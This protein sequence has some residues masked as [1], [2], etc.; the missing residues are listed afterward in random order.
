MVIDLAELAFTAF[1]NMFDFVHQ[2]LF[3]RRCGVG[4]EEIQRRRKPGSKYSKSILQTKE[5]G[6]FQLNLGGKKEEGGGNQQ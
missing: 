3:A 5:T 4:S 1:S 6:A 2:S